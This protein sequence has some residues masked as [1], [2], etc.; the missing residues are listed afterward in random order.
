MV[1]A[2]L[3]SLKSIL[4]DAQRRGLIGHNVAADVVRMSSRDEEEVVIPS[5][6][7]ITSLLIKSAELWPLTRVKVNQGRA[8]D[9]RL[10]M[11]PAHRDGDLHRASLF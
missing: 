2:V 4:R 3:G 10:R 11:A 5:K 6:V 8:E 1:K 9:R 7:Y